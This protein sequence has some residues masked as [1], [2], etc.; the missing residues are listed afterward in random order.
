L[1]AL[2]PLV[3]AFV[4]GFAVCLV[5]TG[6]AE[7]QGWTP[8]DPSTDPW[9]TA[10][11]K[12]GPFFVAPSF[13]LRNVGID[14]NVFREEVN[15]RQDLTATI[16]VST[17]FGVH[18]KAFSFR[19]TQDNRYI[20]F[21]R[22]ASERSIDGGLKYLAELRL[23]QMRPWISF[24]SL[25]STD[26][27]GFEIDTRAA[28]TT[29]NFEAGVDFNFGLRTGMTASFSTN[30]TEYD[31]GQF[32]DGVDLKKTL[33]SKTSFA[34]VNGRWQYSEFTDLTGGF[35]WSESKFTF[36]PLRN[37]ETFAY[38]GGFQSRG[39]A[40]I[41]GRLQLGY[42]LQRHEDPTVPDF[43][44]LVM[45]GA[46]STVVLDRLKLDILADRD[47]N[48]SYDNDF[49]FYVQQGGGLTVTGRLSRRLDLIAS[50]RGEWLNYSE[51]FQS[52]GLGL[53]SRT[54]LATVLGVGFL[55]TVGGVVGSHFGLTFERAERTSPL[56]HKT[57]RNDRVL[58]NL[59]FSF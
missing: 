4:A 11:L 46:V 53:K 30:R 19:V 25:K 45:A 6:R 31:D 57:Y 59:K 50:A 3:R 36:D 7:A 14:N 40:P 10:K 9:N 29:P 8:P 38:L 20:W 54:D 37:A 18:V 13:D 43:K 1:K 22:Y 16:A 5:L 42:K 41:T 51:T 56:P 12:I 15:P 55:Y 34:H 2:K 39:D 17:I 24:E 26:R 48:F 23:Q 49:P 35:E 33:N 52:A 58:T 21:R 47:V 44:G 32:F 28:R 27:V